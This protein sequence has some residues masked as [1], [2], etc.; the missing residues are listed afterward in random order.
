MQ[1]LGS[2][3]G[4]VEYVVS[5]SPYRCHLLFMLATPGLSPFGPLLG[6]LGLRTGLPTNGE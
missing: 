3:P 4:T 2:C 1:V 6:E 5:F